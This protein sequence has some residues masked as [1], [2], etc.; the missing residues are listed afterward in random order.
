MPTPGIKVAKIVPT[1][2]EGWTRISEFEMHS[3]EKIVLKKDGTKSEK[4][5]LTLKLKKLALERFAK[6]LFIGVAIYMEGQIKSSGMNC[7]Q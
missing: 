7:G 1:L 3:S 2:N 5:Q 6:R 4:T